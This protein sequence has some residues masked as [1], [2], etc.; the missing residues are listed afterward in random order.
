MENKQNWVYPA[1]IGVLVLT[2]G[3]FYIQSFS[4]VSVKGGFSCN[5]GYIGINADWENKIQE[6]PCLKS[7][8]LNGSFVDIKL[9]C[10]DDETLLQFIKLKDINGLNCQGWFDVNAPLAFANK[11]K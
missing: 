2:I 6:Y 7:V 4:R 8:L 1:I 10:H 5:T 9:T 3:F 11:L